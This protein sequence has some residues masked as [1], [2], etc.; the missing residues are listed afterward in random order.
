MDLKQK[1]FTGKKKKI[2]TGTQGARF[3]GIV[4]WELMMRGGVGA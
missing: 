2:F 4:S 1:I 3:R